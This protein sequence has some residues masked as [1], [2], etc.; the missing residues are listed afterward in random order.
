MSKFDVRITEIRNKGIVYLG[1]THN[2]YQWASIPI[3]N[4]EIEIPLIIKAL[5][6]YQENK[7]EE[8]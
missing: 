8:K 4:T 1:V 5:Q 2:G 6:D 3:I 7:K